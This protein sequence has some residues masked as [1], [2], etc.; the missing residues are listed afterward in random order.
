[1]R[2]LPVA[3]L[4]AIALAACAEHPAD[5][6]PFTP[7]IQIRPFSKVIVHNASAEWRWVRLNWPEGPAEVFSIEP[8]T[9]QQLD[10]PKAKTGFPRSIDVLEY[11]DCRV[12]ATAIGPPPSDPERVTISDDGVRLERNQFIDPS[13]GFTSNV[14]ECGAAPP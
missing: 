11:S 6:D 1:M 13:W 8:G 12:L 5:Q 4:L 3:M 7:G 10:G 2:A 14:Y 9:Y